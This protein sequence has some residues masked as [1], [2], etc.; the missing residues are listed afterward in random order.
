[1]YS[2]ESVMFFGP[3]LL[4]S[5]CGRCAEF[6]QIGTVTSSRRLNQYATSSTCGLPCVQIAPSYA[7]LSNTRR[8]AL[9]SRARA[10]R[11][12]ASPRW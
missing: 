2:T 1:M 5:P 7:L 8:A 12:G 3:S 9:V 11:G 10:G 6:P 4:I